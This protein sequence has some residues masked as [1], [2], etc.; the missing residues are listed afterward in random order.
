MSPEAELAALAYERFRTRPLEHL[1]SCA[2]G[3]ELV[4]KG[5]E[6][7]VVIAGRL[8]TTDVVP[9]AGGRRVRARAD[10]CRLGP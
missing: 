6:P 5:F 7:D 3:R 9:R 4:E 1:L 2:S 8:N 10:R